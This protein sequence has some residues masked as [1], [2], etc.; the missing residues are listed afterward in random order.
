MTFAVIGITVFGLMFAPS[1]S[2]F[3]EPN[4]SIGKQRPQADEIKNK[5]YVMV[6]GKMM[7]DK[8]AN[9]KLEAQKA[10]T[11]SNKENSK[12]TTKAKS[13][14]LVSSFMKKAE[15]LRKNEE[16]HRKLIQDKIALKT[17]MTANQI[18]KDVASGKLGI[19]LKTAKTIQ[20]GRTK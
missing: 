3:A 2:V 18:K 1:L 17:K 15:E 19:P 4:I 6:K 11:K 8:V 10:T 5:V 14:A 12:T 16:M 13:L 9:M 20:D 7:E